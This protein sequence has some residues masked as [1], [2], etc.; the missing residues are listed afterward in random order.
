M[1]AVVT[2]NKLTEEHKNRFYSA[3]EQYVEDG[4]DNPFPWAAPWT[5]CGDEEVPPGKNIE[6]SARG[7]I[8]QNADEILRLE[9]ERLD[10]MKEDG[11]INSPAA[12]NL[13]FKIQLL[14]MLWAE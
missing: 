6:D 5:W 3:A 8:K 2:F 1:S 4:K 7:W 13:I 9:R 10:F 11:E 14:D 12:D